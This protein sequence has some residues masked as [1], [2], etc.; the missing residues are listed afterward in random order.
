MDM[1][2]MVAAFVYPVTMSLVPFAAAA[3]ARQDGA[4]ANRIVSPPSDHRHSGVPC[5]DRSQRAG[6]SH[7]DPGAPLPI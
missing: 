4:S 5:G 1:P 3:L 6:H 7:H 2:N